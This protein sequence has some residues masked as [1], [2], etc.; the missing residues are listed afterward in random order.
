MCLIVRFQ[1]SAALAM[2]AV[3]V[4]GKALSKMLLPNPNIFKATLQGDK[5]YNS[6]NSDAGP[7]ISCDAEPLEPWKHGPDIMEH[8]KKVNTINTL[9][10]ISN[11]FFSFFVSIFADVAYLC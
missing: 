10:W 3:T 6:N 4:M 9:C 8:L 7:G 1:H 5:V 11:L 2:D